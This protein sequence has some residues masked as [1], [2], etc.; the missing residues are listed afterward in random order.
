MVRP[1][2]E[3]GLKHL[4]VTQQG[5]QWIANLYG[6]VFIEEHSARAPERARREG[7]RTTS[8]RHEGAA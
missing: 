7:D 5:K 2:I 4:A 8:T 1:Y 3:A 6:H